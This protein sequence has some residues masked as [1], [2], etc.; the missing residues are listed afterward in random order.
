[1]HDVHLGSFDLN[2]I[3]AL[4]A[5]L[6]ERSVTRAA[7]R[8]GISQSAM[9]HALSRLRSVTGDALLVRS[10]SGMVPTIRAEALGPPIRRALAD[11]AGALAKTPVFDPKTAR[12]KVIIGTSDYGELVLLPK[13]VARVAREAPG[14][15]LRVRS[16]GD[17]TSPLAS[18]EID[19]SIAP[20]QP[21]DDA[22][23]IFGRRLFDER[24][25]CVV[26]KANPLA[27]KK[28]TLARYVAASHVL[29]TPRETAGGPVDDALA[30]LGMKRR[31]A[32]MVPHFLIAPHVVAATDL[33][34]TVAARVA[35]ALAKPLGLAVLT[36][37][38]ELALGGFTMSAVWHERTQND[39]AQRWI[40]DLLAD[41]A[42]MS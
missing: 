8:I 23:A 33:I 26:R 22:P 10:K 21:T 9:S 5:L 27:G 34:C 40:R 7:A 31:V 35:H 29:I 14:I 6:R 39:P 24:F 32:V 36:P 17:A 18:G 1:M 30:R 25:V 15:D 4:D 2:L 28:L 20:L 41:V 42:K 19:V 3:V 11:V 37:P 13:I 38:P 12:G 16:I